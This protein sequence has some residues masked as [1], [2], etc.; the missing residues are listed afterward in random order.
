M[1]TSELIFSNFITL[2]FKDI[3][4]ET[5]YFES[6]T[7]PKKR[8]LCMSLALNAIIISFLIYYIISL[9]KDIF[10][11]AH[12]LTILSILS[13]ITIWQTIIILC[14]K[15]DTKKKYIVNCF[16][17]CF[18]QIITFLEIFYFASKVVYNN[19]NNLFLYMIAIAEITQGLL[20]IY[21]LE[22]YYFVK[23]I[24]F[25]LALPIFAYYYVKEMDLSIL[26]AI[27]LMRTCIIIMGYI[28]EKRNKALFYFF[29]KMKSESTRTQNLIDTMNCGIVSFSNDGEQASYNISISRMLNNLTGEGGVS[30]N[31]SAIELRDFIFNDLDIL[32][33]DLKLHEIIK[34]KNRKLIQDLF[35][36]LMNED[37]YKEFILL[38]IKRERE[39]I[40]QV[41]IRYNEIF[42]L[43][44]CVVNDITIFAKR[45]EVNVFSRY[46]SLF[47]AK[48]CHEFRNPVS[49]IIYL[50]NTEDV[51]FNMSKSEQEYL[52]L[53]KMKQINNFSR[54]MEL[55]IADFEMLNQ[56]IGLNTDIPKINISKINV[57]DVIDECMEMIN[58]KIKY[59]SK[60]I[61]L[62]KKITGVLP[63]ISTDADKLKQ[64]LINL[65]SNSFKFTSAGEITIE[66]ELDQDKEDMCSY[67]NF[68][69]LDNG[70]GISSEQ[71]EVLENF[72]P[73]TKFEN[74]TNRYGLGVGLVIVK[75]L[76]ELLGK[77][78]KILPLDTKGTKISFK[79]L[80]KQSEQ[81]FKNNFGKVSRSNSSFLLKSLR[82]LSNTSYDL[83]RK[84]GS[85]MFK[86]KDIIIELKSASDSQT[87]NSILVGTEKETL[88]V[89]HNPAIDNKLK[90]LVKY[91]LGECS[92]LD[93]SS[94]I[95]TNFIK[96]IY[97]FRI[98]VIDDEVV[99]RNSH[100]RLLFNY[101]KSRNKL[102]DIIECS[103]SVEAL[104]HLY[105]NNK[106]GKKI[107]F[108][109]SDES[110]LFMR[111]SMLYNIISTLVDEKILEN[112]KFYLITSY[113][114]LHVPV[115]KN[116][117]IN[118]PLTTGKLCQIF[119]NL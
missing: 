48:I 79:I 49:N 71:L 61:K 22:F 32:H 70:M 46:Q 77:G 55:Q 118:K 86:T 25:I 82:K 33:P 4:I 91:E 58:T 106:E 80:C 87:S 23:L 24:S 67:I 63:I 15:I 52:D 73:F 92:M 36:Y 50:S 114:N 90:S 38:G 115:D 26:V 27:F 83:L 116:I 107:D 110:M 74:T 18:V 57:N 78:L 10:L 16:I 94:L 51:E 85:T 28:L 12:D 11:D 102:V 54:I 66:A 76:I 9:T 96:A 72:T 6:I 53:N 39:M 45:E 113:Q 101:F 109:L 97:D 64:I 2:S 43:L 29:K 100:S 41:Y 5:T 75:T 35:A 65:L 68:S 8:L 17:I 37:D 62:I 40:F 93:D 19:N 30:R 103:D 20:Y 108:I 34:N 42:N 56:V 14:I 31:V 119:E 3:S 69:I 111:G 89:S 59:G 47:L 7:N 84:K 105:M 60:N 44:E 117:I 95:N 98:L 99:I 13:A 88:R 112:I 21:F 1:F 81:N 104:Y